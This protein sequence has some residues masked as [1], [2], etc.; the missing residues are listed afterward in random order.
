LNKKLTLL[1]SICSFFLA[2][3][4]I[5]PL[6]IDKKNL[7]VKKGTIESEFEM[8]YD[9]EFEDK[10]QVYLLNKDNLYENYSYNYTIKIPEGYKKNNGIGKFSSVQFYNEN[11][12]YVVGV[13]VGSTNL[14]PVNRKTNAKIIKEYK[15]ALDKKK[16]NLED[17]FKNSLIERGFNKVTLDNCKVVDY[18]NRLFIRLNFSA[19]R[20]IDN[21]ENSASLVNFITYNQKL[22][23]SFM[24][25]SYQWNSI[26]KWESEIQKSMSNVI[27]SKY[28]TKK[29]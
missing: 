4:L 12:G 5:I 3:Y 29:D 18:N 19:F 6:L 11:L 23:Y 21:Q 15:S 1:L 26:E 9:Y 20:T 28:I 7:T 13:N 14:E 8:H 10:I 17:D 25:V 2:I 22:I 16:W 24:F 27:I